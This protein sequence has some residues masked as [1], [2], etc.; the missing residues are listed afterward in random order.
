MDSIVPLTSFGYT[1]H[2]DAAEDFARIMVKDIG[3]VSVNSAVT[4]AEIIEHLKSTKRVADRKTVYNK[5]IRPGYV[6]VL[7]PNAPAR[8]YYLSSIFMG[9]AE[10]Q[11]AQYYP[12]HTGPLAGRKIPKVQVINSTQSSLDV[13]GTI[14][15]SFDA[16]P[17]LVR[18]MGISDENIVGGM[19][20][21]SLGG[22]SK[23]LQN[24]VGKR[25]ILSNA[26][27]LLA[28]IYRWLDHYEGLD[29]ET[30]HYIMENLPQ[31]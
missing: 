30:Q 7:S 10:E 26:I 18:A 9:L 19:L 15:S 8:Y 13:E 27:V 11:G 4:I 25:E 21:Q 1:R 16:E 6:K 29:M 22:I 14:P 5:L 12:K 17:L 20:T 3:A 28:G 2:H 23:V 24:P 31:D